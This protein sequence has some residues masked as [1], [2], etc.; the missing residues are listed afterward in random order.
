MT[1]GILVLLIAAIAAS[2]NGY[3]SN[4]YYPDGKDSYSYTPKVVKSTTYSSSSSYHT[5]Y[6]GHKLITG[7]AYRF[8]VGRIFNRFHRLGVELI[9]RG[10]KYNGFYYG[11]LCSATKLYGALNS[12]YETYGNIRDC[13]PGLIKQGLIGRRH[14]YHKYG[15]GFGLGVTFVKRGIVYGRSFYKFGCR[16]PKFIRYMTS[17]YNKFHHASTC[18]SVLRKRHLIRTPHAYH[19][20]I[21]LAGYTRFRRFKIRHG[22]FRYGGRY[23]KLSCSSR[24]FYSY[25]NRCYGRYHSVGRCFGYLRRKHLFSYY[26]AG[27][28]SVV[29]N[30]YGPGYS[31]RIKFD[32]GY[33]RSHHGF[34]IR[35]N[36]FTYGGIGYKL[37]CARSRFYRLWGQCYNRYHSVGS[38]FGRLKRQHLF[39]RYGGAGYSSVAT[40]AYGP[41]YSSAI[42]F[43]YGYYKSH[44]GFSIRNNRFTYGGIGYKLMCARSRFYRL[45][46]ECYN[47][48]HSVGSCFG[49]LR[50]QHL[51]Y[52]YDGAGYSSV[53]TNAYGPYYSSGITFDYGYY[54]SH[55]G[56]SI[57]NN[58][59]TYGGIAGYS[60]VATNAYGPDYSSGITFDYG[61]YKS[62]HGFSIRN[63]RF[64]YGGI[65]YKLMCA[66]SRFYRLWGE[67][68][69]RYHSVGSCF[70]RLRRQHLFYRYGGAG[71]SSVATNAYGP[72]YSSGITFD[73][74]YYKS[75]HGFSIRNNRFTY[76]GIGYK[77]MCARS[78]FYRLWG[79]CYN[80]YHSVGSCFGRLRRQHL[81][82]RYG[83]AG[84]SSVATNAYGPGYSSGITFDYGYYKSHHGFSIRNNRFT[85]G[86]IG[87]KLMCARS[88]FYRLWGECYNRYHSVGNCF[89]RLRRQH[90]F[91]RYDGAGYSS[92]AHN[93]YGPD[94]S[95]GITFD[96]GYY[97]S[98]HGF[99]IRN[100][101]FTYGGIGYKLM[102]ARSRFYRLWGQCY[103]RYHSV[104]SC[105]GR[106]RRQ[107]LF[108]RY[109]GEDYSHVGVDAYGPG[110]SS[111]PVFDHSYYSSHHGFRIRHHRFSYNGIAY[112]LK[113]SRRRFYRLWGQCYHRYHSVGTCFGRL[114]S[115]HLFYRYLGDH[116][117]ILNKHLYLHKK[118]ADNHV[119]RVHNVAKSHVARISHVSNKHVRNIQY[120]A[121]KH[122]SRIANEARSHMN[123]FKQLV[124]YHLRRLHKHTKYHLSAAEHQ[125]KKHLNERQYQNNKHELNVRRLHKKHEYNLKKHGYGYGFSNG[126]K[127]HAYTFKVGRIFNRF[128]RLGVELIGRGIKYNGFYYGRLCSA[129]QLYSALNSCYKDYGDISNCFPGLIKQ[130]LIGRRHIYHKY[131]HGFGLGVTFVK[132][133]IVYGRS[134]Y[135]YGCRRSKFI[136]Y[137]TSCYNKFHHAS[138][139]V[140]VLRK[141]HL[142]ATPHSYHGHMHLAGYT[143]F[144]R[145]T[146]HGGRFRY[147]GRYYKLSCSKKRFYSYWNRCYGRY[148]SVGRCFGYLRRK[149]LFSYYNGYDGEDGYVA[150]VKEK[151]Y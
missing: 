19:G 83:G 96:Y 7:H 13:F 103:N 61:Y 68:Y 16:R 70:G 147:G 112:K 123:R 78:R 76:G 113:C 47:R 17:C 24:R 149:H 32:Y 72:G 135:K 63:N 129:T 3:S 50:R 79:Q 20:H 104:G 35:N 41:G 77:L 64:T 2:T 115:H 99:S 151:V 125:H 59:F 58:R 73:Y 143:R 4:D 116:Q 60:S 36:R 52:R 56:F 69:N 86:G 10:I 55:H 134:F 122:V 11:R 57:R 21:H 30:A 53:A 31:S 44:H 127:G 106:L 132:R 37:M 80:R 12:C 124:D 85:Y 91:Y 109:G 137:M 54:K 138:T 66:R 51:F 102:C 38:C 89:G 101:R 25:W 18:V 26:N 118:I 105:F 1:C 108:Y 130:G 29:T 88:R 111:G 126:G 23:Y 142:I 65:G 95:S 119:R 93:A 136:R 84:Y 145:F 14:I 62:H 42:T 92:V 150:A 114:R 33:Y 98:H 75:H 94:Y 148:H 45:W 27:Y 48:Y 28:S 43:D 74:G 100:N 40:N 121:N 15:H 87:Y 39:Y 146:I 46:G 6:A 144:R 82:Y 67:C 117:A 120:Q 107:H 71:Y 133:G 9:G 128:H 110:Y 90:L 34:S 97:R 140:S 141:R 139:C 81:F 8:K 5:G 131:G 22:R 49:R